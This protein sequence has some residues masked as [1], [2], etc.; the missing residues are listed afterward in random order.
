LTSP[1]FEDLVEEAGAV[2]VEGWD[3][4]WLAGR[5]T[6]ERP[7]WGYQRLI[8]ERLASVS[9]ALDIQ[10]G[11]G[12]VLA[13]VA[14]L[15]A[16]MVATESWPPNVV[17][18]RRVLRPR[19]VLVV[20]APDAPALPLAGGAFEVVTSRHPVTVWWAEIARVLAPGGTYLG[21]H[22][23]PG[24]NIGLVE[25]FLGAQQSARV[26]RDPDRDVDLATAAGLH[27]VDLRV[28]RLRVEFFDVGAVVYFLRKVVWTVPDFSVERYRDRL[29]QLH[30]QIEREGPFVTYSSRVLMEAHKPVLAEGPAEGSMSKCGRSK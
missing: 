12:E 23:G 8:G 28:E 14:R 10:T 2:P 11:G 21:Q 27:V 18:A 24:S 3:F 22:V 13:G 16:I 15:P 7:S 25:Y 9:A 1:T 19:G 17:K 20:A 29:R 26:A 5:A 6:E 4:S 30:E